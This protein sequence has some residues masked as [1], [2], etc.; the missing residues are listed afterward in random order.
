MTVAELQQALNQLVEMGMGDSEIKLAIQPNYPLAELVDGLWFDQ[1][2]DED[3][4]VFIVSGG[5]DH[6]NPYAPKI[7]FEEATTYF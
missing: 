4:D 6:S 7:A 5:Q 2:Q 1:E 3:A